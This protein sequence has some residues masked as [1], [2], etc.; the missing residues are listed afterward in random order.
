MKPA[1]PIIKR[2]RR[3]A[4]IVALKWVALHRRTFNLKP[5]I[6][7]EDLHARLGAIRNNHPEPLP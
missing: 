5:S 3:A 4:N 6:R 7:I 1:T 2:S